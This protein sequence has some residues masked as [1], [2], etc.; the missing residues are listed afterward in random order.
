VYV[1]KRLALFAAGNGKIF[2]YAA[3]QLPEPGTR[4]ACLL[5][6]RLVFARARLAAQRQRDVFRHVGRE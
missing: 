1:P 3:E 5:A 6:Q 4:S 2:Y